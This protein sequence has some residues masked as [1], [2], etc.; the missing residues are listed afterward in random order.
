MGR[1]AQHHWQG[2]PSSTEWQAIADSTRRGYTGHEHL[3]N[4]MLVHMNG[5]VY[6]PAIGRFLSADPIIDCVQDMAGWNRY[7]YVKNRPLSFTDPSGYST[8]ATRGMSVASQVKRIEPGPLGGSAGAPSG[9]AGG[10]VP[11]AVIVTAPRLVFELNAF[12]EQLDLAEMLRGLVPR[13]GSYD[14]GGGRSGGDGAKQQDEEHQK[15]VEDCIK[16]GNAAASIAG[17]TTAGSIAGY[18]V[19]GPYGAIVGGVAGTIAGGVMTQS[20]HNGNQVAIATAAG[21]AG[22]VVPSVLARGAATQTLGQV[23]G[24][25]YAGMASAAGMPT[26][27]SSM[28]GGLISGI[29]E[30]GRAIARNLRVGA[31]RGGLAGLAGLSVEL[32]VRTGAE[33][34]CSS[35]CEK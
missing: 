31:T 13:H 22:G 8:A 24:G 9:G 29:G 2:A 16:I 33:A 10:E 4:V 11:T 18:Q 12:L 27:I 25:M 28:S 19:G 6:D 5:R 7:S 23:A 30:P 20:G 21:G 35:I 14:G 15:C 34:V 26:V 3:D 32:L 17:S 1:A